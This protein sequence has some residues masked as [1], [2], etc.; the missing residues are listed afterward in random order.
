L[1]GAL[2]YISLNTEKQG[3]NWDAGGHDASVRIYGWRDVKEALGTSFTGV[4]KLDG[5]CVLLFFSLTA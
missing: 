4:E 5:W 1:I 2:L 3:I